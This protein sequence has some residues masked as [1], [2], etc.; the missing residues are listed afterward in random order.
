FGANALDQPLAI[1][2][3]HRL[4]LVRKIPRAAVTCLALLVRIQLLEPKLRMRAHREV[5]PAIPSAAVSLRRVRDAARD[6]RQVTI[7]FANERVER[8]SSQLQPFPRRP[9]F[10]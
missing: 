1:L 5:M 10:L 6:A 7:P 2:L 3:P 4:R 9:D 8:P